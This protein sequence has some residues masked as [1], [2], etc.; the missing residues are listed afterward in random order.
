[1]AS[2]PHVQMRVQMEL[3]TVVGSNRL[4]TLDDKPRLPYTVELVKE[5]LR[6]RTVTPLGFPHT[7]REDDEYEGYLIPKGSTILPIVS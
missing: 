7:V 6:W 3:D 1:M 2:Y 5:C 4:T